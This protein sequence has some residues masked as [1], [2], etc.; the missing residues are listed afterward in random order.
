MKIPNRYEIHY[1]LEGGFIEKP[2]FAI[3]NELKSA[4][5]ACNVEKR[6]TIII[7]TCTN[8]RIKL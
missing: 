7:D 1:V 4:K 3:K 6:P 2:A 8:K 5:F